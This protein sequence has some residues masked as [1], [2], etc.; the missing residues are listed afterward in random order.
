M[1]ASEIKLCLEIV[2]EHFGSYAK[3]IAKALFAE[4]MSFHELRNVMKDNMSPNEVRETMLMLEHHHLLYYTTGR[5]I[6]YRM[7]VENVLRIIRIPRLLKE[8]K[9]NFGKIGGPIV[10]H[11]SV[12]G[13]S[14]MS[15]TIRGVKELIDVDVAGIAETFRAMAGQQMVVRM[16]SVAKNDVGFPIYESDENLFVCPLIVCDGTRALNKPGT[17]TKTNKAKGVLNDSDQDMLWKINWERC[18]YLIRDAMITQMF[19]SLAPVHAD[20]VNVVTSLMKV[21]NKRTNIN[22]AYSQPISALEIINHAKISPSKNQ[23]ICALLRVLSEESNQI[24]KEIGQGSGGTYII[25][26]EKAIEEILTMNTQ[27]FIRERID[28][29]AARIFCL[30]IKKGNL[31][32]DQIEKHSMVPSKEA[33]EVC[34]LLLEENLIKVRHV[35]KGNDFAPART[36][37][38]YYVSLKNVAVHL[39]TYCLATIKNLMARRFFHGAKNR[40]L[41]TRVLKRDF[42]VAQIEGNTELDEEQKKIQI[43]ECD[44]S[45]IIGDDSLKYE[46]FTSTEAKLLCREIEAEGIAFI[47][48]QLL[49]FPLP[50]PEK[51]RRVVKSILDEFK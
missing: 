21:G 24:F 15:D 33:K 13:Q 43:K 20:T 12:R 14:T 36:T 7:N 16:R 17:D 31:E 9:M 35:S 22:E 44:D 11:L 26:Y 27:C 51:K 29:R 4:P 25:Y 8:I 34:A 50:P 19:I 32:E 38:V 41:I 1:A 45:F 30:L 40:N 18:D 49:K 47:S 2:R 6:M 37:Y 42:L 5:T 10:Q 39:N 23:E 48:K 3:A 46:Q 28:D